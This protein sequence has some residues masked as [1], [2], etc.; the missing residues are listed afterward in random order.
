VSIGTGIPDLTNFGDDLL[1]IG[2]TDLDDEGKY[3][4]FNV[5]R[6]LAA[7]GLEE[8]SEAKR[9]KELTD[10]YLTEQSTY[11][12]IRK[13]AKTLGDS[14]VSTPSASSQSMFM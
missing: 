1:A 2:K 7:I 9:I 13:C 6:G 5:A 10:A 11:S 14:I 12:S 8:A 4:R 3:Y